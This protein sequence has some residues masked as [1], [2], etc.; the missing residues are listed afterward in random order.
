MLRSS[1]CPVLELLH[2]ERECEMSC[3]CTPM[4]TNQVSSLRPA[5]LALGCALAFALTSVPTVYAADS[6]TPKAETMKAL[7]LTPTFEKVTGEYPY[8]LNLK[9]TSAAALTV[10]AIVHESVHVH[11]KAKERAVPAEVV[12][13]GES[14]K[15]KDLAAG[16]KITVSADGFKTLELTVP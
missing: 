14:C 7:P 13:A 6:S 16:D 12:K 11:S 10:S 9:N 2:P 3:L 5:V 4:K 1:T 8:V 15:I